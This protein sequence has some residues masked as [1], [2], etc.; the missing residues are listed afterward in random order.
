MLKQTVLVILVA[1]ALA[2]T[3]IKSDKVG[4]EI[5]GGDTVTHNTYP[6]GVKFPVPGAI[7]IWGPNAR[8]SPHG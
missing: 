4:E 2:G 1:S 5:I 8:S 7:W 3:V 6:Y